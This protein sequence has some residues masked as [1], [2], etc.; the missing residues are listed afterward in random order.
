MVLVFLKKKLFSIIVFENTKNKEHKN[1]VLY[2]SLS[3][4]FMYCF[5]EKKKKKKKKE[6]IVLFVFSLFPLF[7]Q[8]KKN[9]INNLKHNF[10]SLPNYEHKLSLKEKKYEKEKKIV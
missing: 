2:C 7:F 1:V 5:S 4:V 6:L 3:L 9:S 10:H 8:K